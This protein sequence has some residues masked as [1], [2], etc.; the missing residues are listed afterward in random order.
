MIA[1]T[2][3]SWFNGMSLDLPARGR[4]EIQMQYGSIGWSVGATL[5]YCMG[6][7]TR[8]VVTCVGY[9]S[10]QLTA[11]EISTMI[12]YG[13]RPIVFL[14]NNGGYTIETEIH[15]GP[16]NTINNW[17]YARLVDVFNGDEGKGWG[18]SAATEGELDAAIAQALDH[19]GLSPHFDVGTPL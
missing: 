15:D 1:E 18:C 10:F 5:G 4:F 8:R 2:G 3:D 13:A 9:G 12:R 16:Y 17:D 14:I 19:D 6:A 11:Q 7:P